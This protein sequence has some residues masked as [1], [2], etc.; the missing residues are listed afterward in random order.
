LTSPRALAISK[1]L[2]S[3]RHLDSGQLWTGVLTGMPLF[4]GVPKR[5]VRKIAA[6]TK[7]IRF[8]SGGSIVRLGE[9]GDGFFVVL[10]GT[11]SVLRAGGLSPI[12]L[13]PGDY[14]GEIALIDGAERTATVMARTEVRCLR[15]GTAPFLK[16]LKSEP[17]IAV[18]M[19][20]QLAGRIREL[21][22]RSHL[23]S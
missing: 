4:A 23:S 16:M 5:H 2:A 17:E 3:P 10:D 7:E 14:F 1:T 12:T 6:L 20:K 9:R 8:P 18:L 19:L 15:L 13:G 22:A 11:A 21:Q